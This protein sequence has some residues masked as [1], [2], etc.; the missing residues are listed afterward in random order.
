MIF[1]SKMMEDSLKNLNDLE[2]I[3][4]SSG[5]SDIIDAGYFE[6]ED[7]FMLGKS[8]SGEERSK[9]DVIY[10]NLIEHFK[11][12]V[13]IEMSENYIFAEKICDSNWL[14]NALLFCFKFVDRFSDLKNV[15]F[16]LKDIRYDEFPRND[17]LIKIYKYRE[18]EVYFVEDL[19]SYNEAIMIFSADEV[20]DVK[21][22]LGYDKNLKK[23]PRH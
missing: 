13:G 14:E 6:Y 4:I 19:D 22:Y 15:R 1:I 10:K 9:I 5:L 21:A 12:K 7:T 17:T 16:F 11:D 3:H 2:K 23:L 8:Y 18:E 20:D